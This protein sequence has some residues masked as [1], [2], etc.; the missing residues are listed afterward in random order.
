MECVFCPPVHV[1]VDVGVLPRWK[2]FAGVES[3]TDFLDEQKDTRPWR[4]RGFSLA[5]ASAERSGCGMNSSN[6][7]RCVEIFTVDEELL[8]KATEEGPTPPEFSL[9]RHR[10]FIRPSLEQSRSLS[11]RQR[12]P[13]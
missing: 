6:S 12:S 2:V 3:C 1:Q 9:L 4:K 7:S 5:P 10:H 8:S 13:W 11:P